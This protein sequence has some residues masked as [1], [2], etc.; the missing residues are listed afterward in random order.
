MK[1]HEILRGTFYLFEDA[2]IGIKDVLT[3][4]PDELKLHKLAVIE[5]L[6]ERI[7]DDDKLVRE[8]LFQLFKAVIFPGCKEVTRLL[9]ILLP[10]SVKDSNTGDIAV[11]LKVYNDFQ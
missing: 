11:L 9:Y 4:N 2:L 10:F 5:K 1:M 6:R 7:S 3:K 8:T